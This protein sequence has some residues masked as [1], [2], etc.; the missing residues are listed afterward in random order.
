VATLQFDHD[1]W[2]M[3]GELAPTQKSFGRYLSE[4]VRRDYIRRQEW[5]QLRA[6]VPELVDVGAGDE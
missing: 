2:A 1:A 6:A 3:L 5:Q 4:L